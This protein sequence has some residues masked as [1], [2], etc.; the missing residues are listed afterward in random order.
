MGYGTPDYISGWDIDITKELNQHALDLDNAGHPADKCFEDMELGEKTTRF[1]RDE[2][3][4]LIKRATYIFTK[5][6]TGDWKFK[7]EDNS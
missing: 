1:E 6:F 7:V 2:E 3:D 5:W 4:M